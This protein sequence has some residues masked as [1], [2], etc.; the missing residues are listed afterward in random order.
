MDMGTGKTRTMLEIIK[1]KMDRGK[2]EKVIWF[3]PCSAKD[4]ILK[5]FEKHITKG[6][7]AIIIAGIESVSSSIKLMSF[8]Y[9]FVEKYET[10]IVV[11]ESTKIKNISTKRSNRITK[12]GEKCR[13]RYILSGNVTPRNELDLYAQFNFLDWRILGYKSVWSFNN[14]HAIY[15]REYTNRIVG[16]KNIRYLAA[17]IA[18]YSYQ[19][20][21]DDCVQL[22]EQIFENK[23]F[24]LSDEQEEMY[25]DFAEYFTGTIDEWKPATIYRM[26]SILLGITAGFIYKRTGNKIEN[27]AYN[28]DINTNPR[29]KYLVDILDDFKE[30]TIIYCEY[31]DEVKTVAKIINELYGDGTAVTFFGEDSLK[32]RNENIEKF[33]DKARFLIANKECASYSL[34]LQFCNHIIYYN[35]DWDYGTKEQ[36]QDRIYRIGQDKKTYYLNIYCS[37]TI[38]MFVEDCLIRKKSL[39]E[40]FQ[41]AVDL[42]EKSKSEV[43][44]EI[45]KMLY[46]GGR[47]KSVCVGTREEVIQTVEE[48]YESIQSTKCV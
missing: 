25:D 21:L 27:V 40:T 41:K 36:S 19:V 16:V 22:P 11:D 46:R 42:S 39:A 6:S 35:N 2:V 7:K 24:S 8:L 33:R 31:V 23:Y 4:N 29:L 45:Y 30:K 13:Y 3:C 20:K 26:F 15:H 37:G 32:K 34:N 1:N 5:E 28:S 17:K 43:K 44:F 18:P 12:L 38:E 9:S 14:N 10:L 48:L 47:M